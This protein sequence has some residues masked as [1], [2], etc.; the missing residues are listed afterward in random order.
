MEC[1]HDLHTIRVT[2]EPLEMSCA[3]AV[4]ALAP[5]VGRRT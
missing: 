1:P 3:E 5:R 2:I 4:D